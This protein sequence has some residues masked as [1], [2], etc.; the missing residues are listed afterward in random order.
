M[1]QPEPIYPSE[2]S[3]TIEVAQEKLPNL[4]KQFL[5]AL[6]KK[7]LEMFQKCWPSFELLK[8]SYIPL[9][10]KE[11]APSIAKLREKR[12]ELKSRDNKL[13]RV[14]SQ[15]I[16]RLNEHH[17]ELETLKIIEVSGN[18]VKHDDNFIFSKNIRLKFMSDNGAIIEFNKFSG[19]MLGEYW[20]LKNLPSNFVFIRNG[21]Q[22]IVEI[23]Q[24]EDHLIGYR[25]PPN[26]RSREE[27]INKRLQTTLKYASVDPQSIYI[28][29]TEDTET[30]KVDVTVLPHGN[31]Q[32]SKVTDAVFNGIFENNIP[33]VK[34]IL[35]H[36]TSITDLTLKNINQNF[37]H[38]LEEL[39]V[40]STKITDEGISFLKDCQKLEKLRLSKT[41]ISDK[42]LLF[43]KAC[44][45]L[46]S[47]GLNGTTI[48]GEGLS[49]LK[50]CK[51]L[52]GIGLSG[53]MIT[54]QYGFHLSKLISLNS[55]YL[56]ET[57]I[58]DEFMYSLQNLKNLHF[59]SLEG[60]DISDAGIERLK[61][62]DSLVSLNLKNTLVGDESIIYLKEMKTLNRLDL[63][64]TQI[65]EEAAKY[66]K[67]MK[68]LTNMD[69]SR[70]DLTR[71]AVAQLMKELPTTVILSDY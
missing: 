43:L 29:Q 31:I 24:R 30:K 10:E 52:A 68:F 45:Q 53:T 3:Y 54:D 20:Y 36:N 1:I 5:D 49:F 59:L 32:N 60:T 19:A 56:G 39:D 18:I 15:I 61:K 28:F 27:N 70:T 17:I 47:I 2:K 64:Y 34:R 13:K 6:Q 14:Y 9:L 38:S 44:K 65:T 58:T 33:N 7:K 42:G 67:N 25:P 40:S 12:M 71:E 62:L 37:S 50:D 69:L 35:C 41:A 16:K 66:L 23:G 57:Q 26:D 55:L 51:Q 63:R 22:D 8:E 11:R 4:A 48:T 46:K 21:K